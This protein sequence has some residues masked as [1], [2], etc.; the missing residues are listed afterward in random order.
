MT[1]FDVSVVRFLLASLGCIG[2][3]VGVWAMTALCR[4]YLPAVATQR[5]IWLLGQITVGGAFLVILLPHS[6]RLRLVPPI[7]LSSISEAGAAAAGRTAAALPV[8]SADR[9]PP[10]SATGRSLLALG[11]EAWLALYLL[12]LGYSIIRLLHSQ[13]VLSHL[14]GTGCPVTSFNRHDGFATA[15]LHGSTLP[16]I[17]VDAPISPMLFGL[18]RPRLLL[19]RHLR[20]F[21]VVQQQ[22][23]VAHELTHWRRHDLHW[24]GAGVFLETLFWFNPFMRVLRVNLSWAQELGCDRDVLRGRPHAER[25]A[26]AAALVAQLKLQH[27]PA[28][29]AL[30]FGGVSANTLGARISLI[31]EPGN[32]SWRR[33]TRCA[34]FGGLAAVFTASLALQPALAWQLGPAPETRPGM[35]AALLAPFRNT[36]LPTAFSCTEL[37]D[38]AT[39]RRLLRQGECDERVTPASTFNIAISL[40]GY[41]SAILKDEHTPALPFKEG[42]ADWNPAW[43][44]T[45]DPASW[46]GHSVLWYAQE[47]TSRLGA[48]RFQR[49]V[50]RFDYGNHDVSGDPGKDNG[51]SLSWVGSSL[52]ISPREQVDFLRRVVNRNLPLT[53]KA[54]DTTARLLKL[55]TLPSGWD[56]YG[57]TGT[58][59]PVLPDGRDDY[60]RTYGWFVG[61]ATKG[62]R[63]VVFARL[64]LEPAQ[65]GSSAGPRAKEAFLRDL[66]ARLESL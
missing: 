26:Y 27:R 64:V 2:A 24:M 16:V 46:I 9:A 58:A 30:A 62:Q 60:A 35:T 40:M 23:I 43:R 57:K 14:A 18:F 12:G 13:R 41:D 10:T 38:A 31:R 52:K 54:Y 8:T 66:P 49:Y 42:Y 20:S 63:T 6:E 59:A 5:T 15:P 1:A 51:L 56:I 32:T 19:P 21:D 29:T 45:T 39:G 22:M 55:Q 3:G 48:A 65:E 44:A 7:E 4:R 37:A 61:W 36:A 34:T 47:V 33:W 53:P 11:A 25:K 17:E 50:G 28:N